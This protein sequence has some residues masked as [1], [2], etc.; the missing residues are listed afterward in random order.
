MNELDQLKKIF[1]DSFHRPELKTEKY[2]K[3]W[4]SLE[5]INDM[6]AGPFYAIYSNGNCDYVFG[7]KEKFPGIKDVDDF[8]D[9]CTHWS[10]QY[11]EAIKKESVDTEEERVDREILLFQTDLKMELSQ[12]AYEIQKKRI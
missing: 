6:L 7:D 5:P 9:Y 2:K 12:L 4:E 11:L 8:L 1:W 10:E 3:L